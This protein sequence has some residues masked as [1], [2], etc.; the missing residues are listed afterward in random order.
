MLIL[1]IAARQLA[2]GLVWPSTLVFAT[3]IAA[4]DPVAVIAI[5]R[6]L[7]APRRLALVIE[8]ESLVNDGT[9]V[10]LYS[11]A[12]SSVGSARSG[13]WGEAAV[14]FVVVVGL[15]TAVGVALGFAISAIVAR[16]DDP[17]VEITLTT[18]AAYG[19][20]TL[21]EQLHSSGVLAT[22]AAGLVCGS[23]G[24]PRGMSST[25]RVAVGSFWEYVAFALNSIVFLMIGFEVR[26]RNLVESAGV[27]ALAYVAIMIARAVMVTFVWLAL[28]PSRERMPW[29]WSGV[30]AWGGIRGALSIVLALALTETFP[31]R[32]LIVRVTF[33]VAVLSILLNG[34]T[35]GPLMRSLSL[36]TSSATE[37]KKRDQGD[38][39]P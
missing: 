9:A 30:L 18:I 27:I 31:G 16:V 1:A 19:S 38:F 25:S 39:S 6:N 13:V 12:L 37:P 24:A 17:V 35:V 26:T 8:G 7:R 15:G 10:I 22:V 29:R 32:E 3:L 5:F 23:Y 11:L 2:T 33:G 36:A 34:L 20:F 4:T 14:D 21:A 28:R